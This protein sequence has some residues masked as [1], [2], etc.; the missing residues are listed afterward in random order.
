MIYRYLSTFLI[1]ISV[2]I[3]FAQSAESPEITVEELKGHIGYLASDD[4]EGR[5]PG[6]PGIEK[7]ANYIVE[8]LKKLEATPAGD[9]YFQTLE[10][11]TEMKLGEGNMLSFGGFKGKV[12]EDFIPLNISENGEVTASA[13]FVG[14]G[15]QIDEDSLKWDDYS[16]MDTEGK[17]V[18]IMRGSPSGAGGHGADPYE[19]H[20]SLRKKIL[21][22]RDNKAA[23]V[24]FVTGK[25][26][27]EAD[28]LI[29]LSFSR[30]ETPA[31]LPALHIKREVFNSLIADAGITIDDLEKNI[32]EIKAPASF[33][34]D[35]EIN[36][37]A[38]LERIKAATRNVTAIIEGNDPVLKD[39]FILIGAHYDHLG[40][41]GVGSGSRAPDTV[42]IHNGADDNASGTAAAI[43][44]FEKLAANKNELKRSILFMAF[45]AEE[46]GLVGSKYFADNPFVDLDK[47]NFMINMDMVGRLD[48]DTKNLTVG[49][50]GTAVGLEDMLKTHV[51]KSGL[52]VKY[53]SEGYGPS[54]HASFYAKDI[55]VMF[56]FTGVHEDYHTPQDDAHLI[57]YEGEKVVADLVYD[58][59]FDI[60]NQTDALVYQEAGPKEPQNT[61]KRFK[62]TLGIMPD[63][64]S[65][66]VKGVRADAVIEGRP[67]YNAGMQKGDII[68]AMEGKSVNDIYDY[69]NRLA[70]FEPGQRISV[71]VKRGDE[72]VVLIVDL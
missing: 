19:N 61:Y 36:G 16:E 5:K 29:K 45:T 64:A 52:N 21:T 25:E 37:V 13:V 51:D 1:L 70:D 3:A 62:V 6:T 42:A 34:L 58:V 33:E 46:M 55:P 10:I 71:D 65:S 20:S 38:D 7:A 67:A 27:Q 15:F 60:A 57:N 31:G 12:E 11:V 59:A 2:T 50:T 24:M 9:D 63:V 28:D 54:D 53:S 56:V 66:D 18:I 26:F 22:A 48:N 8:Q 43:E 72:T 32:N 68:I 39:E 47:I 69:M 17:W 49:G 40:Y 23:G 41:G 14:Y 4:L 30:R 35:V 44:V